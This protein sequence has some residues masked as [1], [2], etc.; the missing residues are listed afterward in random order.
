MRVH[1]RLLR[2]RK[3]VMIAIAVLAA[4]ACAEEPPNAPVVV[5][6]AGGLAP[7]SVEL[8]EVSLVSGGCGL[9]PEDGGAPNEPVRTVLLRREGGSESLGEVEPGRD[10]LY[11]RAF[12]ATCSVT[13]AGCAVADVDPDGGGEL[14]VSI[15]PLGG[16]RC[17]TGCDEACRPA[18]TPECGD[19]VLS[20]EHCD[21]ANGT[22]GDGCDVE[23]RIE[24]GFTCDAEE[25]SSCA[26]I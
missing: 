10:Y 21:D 4:V 26:A 8:V 13:G 9:Q 3:L 23:C 24:P 2:L 15:A 1:R 5:R 19:G 20:G 6:F 18:G 7:E 22:G 14:V 11:A 16:P 12:D 17:G 25:P